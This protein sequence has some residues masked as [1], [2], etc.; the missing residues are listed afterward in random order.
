MLPKIFTLFV[1]TL[2]SFSNAQCPDG[3]SQMHSNSNKC[4]KYNSQN[5]IPDDSTCFPTYL[6]A[7]ESEQENDEIRGENSEFDKTNCLTNYRL[8][9]GEGSLDRAYPRSIYWKYFMA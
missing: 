1:L 8:N 5:I 4:Y 7:I 6:L 3:F 9:R 2:F